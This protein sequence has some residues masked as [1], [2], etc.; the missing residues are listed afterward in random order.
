M[1]ELCPKY[2]SASEYN[3]SQNTNADISLSTSKDGTIL[4]ITS[5]HLKLILCTRNY[6]LHSLRISQPLKEL[7]KVFFW[8]YSEEYLFSKLYTNYH[9]NI[10]GRDYFW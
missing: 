10:C 7:K 9:Q 3:N 1:L 5:L 8:W 2:D 6:P 4:V